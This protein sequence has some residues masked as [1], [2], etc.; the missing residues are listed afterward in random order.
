MYL[1]TVFVQNV[2]NLQSQSIELSSGFNYLFGPNGSGKTALLEAVHILARGRS[3]RTNRIASVITREAKELIVRGSGVSTLGQTHTMAV[4]KSRSGMTQL[5]LD[6][7]TQTRAS[8]IAAYLPIQTLLPDAA[9]LIFGGPG[10]RRGF[11]DWGVFHVER[12]FVDTSRNYRRL[13]L[14]RNAW[15]RSLEGKDPGLGA[16][17]WFAQLVDLAAQLSLMRERYLNRFSEN[18]ALMLKLLSPNL[19][20]SIR[21]DW[22][23][24]ESF[25]LVEKKLTESWPRDVKLAATQRG[26]QRADLVFFSAGGAAAESVSR[27]QAKLVASAAI[28]AQAEVLQQESG[29][30]SVF[31]IDD[32]GAELDETHWKHFLETLMALQ[33]QVIATSAEPY[34]ALERLT[35]EKDKGRVFHVEHGKLQQIT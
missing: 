18:F 29:A 24:L 23:G 34:G 22:G 12:Q 33:C 19:D 15:L 6:G 26:P 27:G 5:R 31:L 13:L 35:L 9:E 21:Y 10:I 25:D 16:D 20:I 2:R 17:P 32:F 8:A 28:L 3:F 7:T 1:N 14:Q 11:L 4:S 30:K